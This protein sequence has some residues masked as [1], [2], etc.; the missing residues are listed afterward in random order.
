MSKPESPKMRARRERWHLASDLAGLGDEFFV[1]EDI[2]TSA[3][4]V[5]PTKKRSIDWTWED[6]HRALWWGLAKRGHM[7]G[8]AFRDVVMS[9]AAGRWDC[10]PAAADLLE[11]DGIVDEDLLTL[12]RKVR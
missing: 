1:Y 12:M 7:P 4:P 5:R 3:L 6:C 11:Q 8:Q 2:T 9:L 10:L